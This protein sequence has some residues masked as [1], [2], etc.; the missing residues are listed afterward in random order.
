[1]PPPLPKA[2]HPADPL[3]SDVGR[4]QRAEAVP[5]QPHCLVADVD[6]PFEQQIL[7]IAQAQR[8]THI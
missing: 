5:P 2:P 4:E 3:A 7:D 6:A 8:E 1:M